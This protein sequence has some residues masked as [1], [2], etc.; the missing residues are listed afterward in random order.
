MT[1]TKKQGSYWQCKAP[2]ILQEKE[3]AKPTRHSL[4]FFFPSSLSHL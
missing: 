1:V 2:Q 3:K 4:P